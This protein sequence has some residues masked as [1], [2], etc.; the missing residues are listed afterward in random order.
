MESSVAWMVENGGFPKEKAPKPQDVY[1]TGFL[2]AQP[3]LH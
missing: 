2:P 1:M 3:V